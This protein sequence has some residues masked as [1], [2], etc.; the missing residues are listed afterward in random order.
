LTYLEA[1]K[2]GVPIVASEWATIREYFTDQ[3]TKASTL[4]DQITYVIPYHINT[5][6][7]H[8]T[9]QFGRKIEKNTHPIFHRT[10]IDVANDLMAAIQSV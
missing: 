5:I 9:R 6:T 3:I 7:E 10:K 1:A 8:V 4:G 2:L